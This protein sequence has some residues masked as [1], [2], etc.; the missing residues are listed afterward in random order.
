[1][2]RELNIPDEHTAAVS[3]VTATSLERTVTDCAGWMSRPQALAAVDQLLRAGAVAA[4]ADRIS[5][6]AAA[7]PHSVRARQILAV[8]DARSESPGESQTRCLII[9]AGFPRPECQIPLLGGKVRLDMGY[10]ELH[11]AVEYDGREH[12]SL[13]AARHDK[14]RRRRIGDAGWNVLV[15]TRD[16]ILVNPEIFYRQL[17][18]RMLDSG[19]RPRTGEL[20]MIQRRINYICMKH[21]QAREQGRLLFL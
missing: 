20:K 9:D 1:M 14:E 8:A 5:R 18:R 19:W 7:S 21:R 10:P 3:E 4:A 6:A 16:S 17:M 13:D 12:H 2:F 15:V 11:Q